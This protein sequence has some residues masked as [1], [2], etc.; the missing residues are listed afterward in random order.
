MEHPMQDIEKDTNGVIRFRRNDIVRALL[1]TGKLNMNDLALLPFSDE[2]RR[3]FAQLIG[4]SISGYCDLSY[5]S[6]ADADAVDA[7]VEAA[8]GD[9]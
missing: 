6:E 4:Y 9:R 8:Y 1:D 2:D 5:V 3:Q 7:A